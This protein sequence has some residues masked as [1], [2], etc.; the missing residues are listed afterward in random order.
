MW[1]LVF[2]Q[3]SQ[4]QIRKIDNGW[5]ERAVLY[6]ERIQFFIRKHEMRVY[7]NPFTL[8]VKVML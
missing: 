8:I 1:F 4:M 5:D 6:F 2:S 3:K 7:G